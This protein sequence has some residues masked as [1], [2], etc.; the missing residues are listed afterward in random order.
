MNFE[1]TNAVSPASYQDFAWLAEYLDGSSLCEFNPITKEK[2][3]YYMINRKFVKKFGLIGHGVKMFFETETGLFSLNNLQL[4][5]SYKVNDKDYPLT[6]YGNGDYTDIITYKDA[7]TDANIINPSHQF[8][9]HIHQYNFGFKK[10]LSFAD[11]SE[12]ALQIV[13]CIPYNSNA[14]LEIKIVPNQ[15]LDGELYIKKI[16]KIAETIHAPLKSDHAG[17]CEWIIK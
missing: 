1:T 7:Y 12:F 11:G 14:Y 10:K 8:V 17:I 3:D 5:L 16:G 13:C 15:D 9:S 2:N 4:L 6:G